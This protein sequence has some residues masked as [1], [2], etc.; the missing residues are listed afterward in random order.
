[1]NKFRIIEEETE[2]KIKNVKSKTEYSSIYKNAKNKVQKVKAEAQE[3]LNKIKKEPTPTMIKQA[4]NENIIDKQTADKLNDNTNNEKV[5][6]DAKKNVSKQ[7]FGVLE[8]IKNRI[9]KLLPQNN[10][11]AL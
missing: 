2:E 10:Q 4:K 11:T 1:M 8:N 3:L 6:D 5:I 9:H 7:A